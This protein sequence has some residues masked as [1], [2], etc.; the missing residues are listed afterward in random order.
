MRHK[1]KQNKKNKIKKKTIAQTV[2]NLSSSA[3]IS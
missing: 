1:K 3:I 2:D